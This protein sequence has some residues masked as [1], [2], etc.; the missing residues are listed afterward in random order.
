MKLKVGSNPQDH[1][2]YAR[3]AY[4]ENGR[5]CKKIQSSLIKSFELLFT[6][7]YFFSNIPQLKTY[8][9]EQ[10]KK[11]YFYNT[12]SSEGQISRIFFFSNK[13]AYPHDTFTRGLRR[14]SRQTTFPITKTFNKS[15]QEDKVMDDWNLAKVTPIYKNRNTPQIMELLFFSV[16]GKIL[17]ITRDKII[18]FVEDKKLINENRYRFRNR[19]LCFKKFNRFFSLYI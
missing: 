8:F 17:T 5:K 18:K 10:I 6:I 16:L 12:D 7:K 3:Q 9:Q 14:V 1:G 2:A 13:S 19:R 11:S 4:T 15:P